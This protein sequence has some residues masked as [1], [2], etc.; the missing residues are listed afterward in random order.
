MC[1]SLLR[2]LLIFG[3]LFLVSV[4]CDCYFARFVVYVMFV[5]RLTEFGC[6]LFS[7]CSSIVS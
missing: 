7:C 2:C 1:V 3:L 4:L 6:W 5:C